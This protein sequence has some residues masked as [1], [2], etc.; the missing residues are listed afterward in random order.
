MELT[1]TKNE[2]TGLIKLDEA[3][4]LIVSSLKDAL[5]FCEKLNKL[6]KDAFTGV[7]DTIEAEGMNAELDQN[8]NDL[9]IRANTAIE[10]MQV[11][12]KPGTQMMSRIAKIFT[13]FENEIEAVK[14]TAQNHRDAWARKL[15]IEKKKA[16]AEI[17]KNQN[18]AREKTELKSEIEKQVRE[19]YQNKLYAFKRAAQDKF[20]TMTLSN[21]DEIKKA[22]NDLKLLYPRDKFYELS[23]NITS[24]YMEPSEKAA[25]IFDT[26]EGLYN[27]LSANFRENMEDT[28]QSLLNQISSRVNELREQSKASEETKLQMQAETERRQREEEDQ[29]RKDNEAAKLAD[30]QKVEMAKNIENTAT[31]FDTTAQMANLNTGSGPVRQ[32]YKITVLSV[33]GW[34]AIVSYWFM[35][36]GATNMS[37]DDIGGKKLDQMKKFCETHAHKNPNEKLVHD[38]VIYEEDFKAVNVKS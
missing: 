3:N 7:L 4:E 9:I 2:Q 17:I 31:L 36:A 1:E 10:K 37:M 18:I 34:M 20:N 21:V 24:L 23:V 25:L 15:A 12:R 22:L 29:L 28:Q 27:E 14:Q 13:T 6:A 8:L 30:A 26:R 33:A 16:E 32:G 11:K 35:K 5:P 19:A 38:H